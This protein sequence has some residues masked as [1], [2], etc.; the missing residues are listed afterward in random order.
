MAIHTKR[1]TEKI[2]DIFKRHC[3][4]DFQDNSYKNDEAD[5][6]HFPIDETETEL[7]FIEVYLPNVKEGYK[8]YFVK[9]QND[10]ELL[11][12]ENICEVIEYLNE[13]DFTNYGLC[14]N[15]K[16]IDQCNCC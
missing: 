3:I 2:I 12:T 1:K 14:R 9:N 7:I 4:L 6:L 16:P 10:D 11:L 8:D 5:S 13:Q 15:G